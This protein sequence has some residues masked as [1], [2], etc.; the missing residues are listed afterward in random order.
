MLQSRP[1]KRRGHPRVSSCS[2][3]DLVNT[4]EAKM[5]PIAS[6]NAGFIVHWCE[7]D[8]LSF[9]SVCVNNARY[10][11]VEG[12]YTIVPRVTSSNDVGQA[13]LCEWN[14]GVNVIEQ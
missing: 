1:I 11:C 8:L 5:R 4:T 6:A 3:V 12:C 7:P 10:D 13:N 9:C 14:C 2:R